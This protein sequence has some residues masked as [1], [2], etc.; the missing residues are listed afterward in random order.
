MLQFMQ[1]LGARA[2]H[3]IQRKSYTPG[4]GQRLQAE[5]TDGQSLQ[6]DAGRI[7]V[8]QTVWL[9]PRFKP[10]GTAVWLAESVIHSTPS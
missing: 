7:H 6:R 9:S 2:A 10:P 5:G 1:E 8:N 3:M 4:I